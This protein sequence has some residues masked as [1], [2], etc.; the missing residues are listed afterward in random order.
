MEYS[1]PTRQNCVD[2][3]FE[4][5]KVDLVYLNLILF[6]FFHQVPMQERETQVSDIA[7]FVIIETIVDSKQNWVKLILLLSLKETC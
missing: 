6:K 1:F 2:E 7:T 5:I 4:L 3:L